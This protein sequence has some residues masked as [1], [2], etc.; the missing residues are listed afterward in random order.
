MYHQE[1]LIA[2]IEKAA[3]LS[4]TQKG[5]LTDLYL[6]N[7]NHRVEFY[8]VIR[9]LLALQAGDFQNM[10][11]FKKT[12]FLETLQT[13]LTGGLGQDSTEVYKALRILSDAGHTGDDSSSASVAVR[14]FL[15]P[16][17][18]QIVR[19]DRFAQVKT[20]AV[21]TLVHLGDPSSL[22]T[23]LADYLPGLLNQNSFS[24]CSVLHFI[25]HTFGPQSL[26]P[27][28]GYLLEKERAFPSLLVGLLEGFSEESRGLKD[29]RMDLDRL[30][31]LCNQGQDR[32]LHLGEP[33]GSAFKDP[34]RWSEHAK[35][36]KSCL[37]RW[38]PAT[39]LLNVSQEASGKRR[40]KLVGSR[41][42]M[43]ASMSPDS[44]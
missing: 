18:A 17:I 29:Q 30:R 10:A 35:A 2:K 8:Q 28:I 12:R 44:I 13:F 19:S 1:S 22:G 27:V 23:G 26:G 41:W 32:V 38:D 3:S 20:D 14:R 42:S 43:K 31:N 6:R 16:K 4:E 25:F 39:P 40:K 37:R 7:R 33:L 15:G 11:L 21:L 5:R 24:A 9:G 34:R 36:F